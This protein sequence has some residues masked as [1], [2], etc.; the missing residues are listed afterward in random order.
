MDNGSCVAL[1]CAVLPATPTVPNLSKAYASRGTLTAWY[2]HNAT[3]IQAALS[4][5]ACKED[6]TSFCMSKP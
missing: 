1:S 2:L 6:S 4:V 3:G 5:P